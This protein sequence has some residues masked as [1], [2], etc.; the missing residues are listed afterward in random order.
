[1][2]TK[3]SEFSAAIDSRLSSA[4]HTVSSLEKTHNW[5]IELQKHFAYQSGWGQG[6]YSWGLDI[7][8][9]DSSGNDITWSW[10]GAYASTK[11]LLGGGDDHVYGNL[12]SDKV[13]TGAGDDFIRGVAGNDELLGGDGDD[14]IYGDE[15]NDILYGGYGNDV[16]KGG[17]GNDKLHG[18]FGKNTLKGGAG[19][20]YLYAGDGQD[21]LIGRSGD[22]IFIVT[23]ASPLD[24]ADVI[25]DFGKGKDRIDFGDNVSTVYMRQVNGDTILQNSD[26]DDAQDYVVLKGY[27][28]TLDDIE[29]TYDAAVDFTFVNIL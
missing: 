21:I 1:M 24:N 9:V 6:S 26:A 7:Y 4:E 13:H 8:G 15:G 16:L 12:G 2:S 11:I 22:D 3:P 23:Q 29:S 20:D 14:I 17:S 28:G 25:R 10:G 27:P 19:N 5:E 18:D